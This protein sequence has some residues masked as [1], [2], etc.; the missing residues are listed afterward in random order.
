MFEDVTAKAGIKSDKWTVATGWFD[1][2]NEGLLDLFVV[3]YAKF[4]LDDDRYCGDPGRHLRAYVHP[5]YFQGLTNTLYHNRGNG[6]FEDVTEKSGIGKFV[7]RGM[8]VAFA[9][10]DNDDLTDIFVTNDT[11]ANLLFHNRGDGTFDEVALPSGV[12]LS[13]NGA[14]VSSMGTD[15][16][17]YDND[18]RPDIV[19]RDLTHETFILFRN[20]GNGQ[21]EDASYSSRLSLLS[22]PFSGW[23]EGF[24]DLNNDGWKD[25]FSANEHVDDDIAMV[26]ATQYKQAN[27]VF[28]NQG[29]GTFADVTPEA[30]ADFQQP[31]S[32][33]GV[34][35]ADFN[36]DW[37]IDAVVSS[38]S[39]PADLWENVSPNEN[40]WIVIRPIG[41]KSNRDGIGTRV[42]IGNQVNEMASAVGYASSS[43]FGV[44]FG[45]GKRQKI[46]TIEL[47]WPSGITQMLHDVKMDRYLEVREAPR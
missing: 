2:D 26:Q 14:P 29:D 36:Q 37:K 9:D 17:D 46:D 4:S 47:R 33:R 20:L 43:H 24:Y 25:L 10:Y 27:T 39:A 21:F 38:L 44:H 23:G 42:R 28:A 6:T 45:L 7:G 12:A 30:G 34:A 8:S 16:R 13:N 35:F 41:T 11:Q 32:H 31:N 22:A 18:G 3:N 19:V 5:S 15:F 1:Y 40:H